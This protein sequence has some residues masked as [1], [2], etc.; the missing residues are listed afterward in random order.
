MKLY[1]SLSYFRT[2]M[3]V[4]LLDKYVPSL[5]HF[6]RIALSCN[7]IYIVCRLKDWGIFSLWPYQIQESICSSPNCF[8]SQLVE[9]LRSALSSEG[10]KSLIGGTSRVCFLMYGSNCR[11]YGNWHFYATKGKMPQNFIMKLAPGFALL[12]Q[13][14]YKLLLASTFL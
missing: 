10:P 13:A 7:I 8:S 3:N 2:G 12:S 1:L 4:C 11:L 6:P 14:L 5:S 9:T